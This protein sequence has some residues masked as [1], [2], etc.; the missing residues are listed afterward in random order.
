MKYLGTNR[1]E[2]SR[3]ILRKIEENDYIQAFNNWCNDY[4]VTK[5]TLWDKHNSIDETKQFFDSIISSYNEKQYKWIIELK[6]NHEV[7]GTIDI[8]NKLIKYGTGELSYALSRKYWNKGYCTEA[9][10]KVLDYM[11]NECEMELIY[12]QFEELNIAS[13]KVMEKI[14]MT[15]E[16]ILRSRIVDKDGIR[17]SLIVYSITKDEY[18]TLN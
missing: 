14:G 18:N 8:S 3:L 12:A 17:N 7:I 10:I 4:E 15:K 5:Y 11:F 2:T 16:G 6:E 1:L 9:S 13:G